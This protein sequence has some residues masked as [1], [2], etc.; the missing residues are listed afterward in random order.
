MCHFTNR[1]NLTISSF[2]STLKTTQNLNKSQISAGANRATSNVQQQSPSQRIL[3]PFTNLN[4]N[5]YTQQINDQPHQRSTTN[6]PSQNIVSPSQQQQEEFPTNYRSPVGGQPQQPQQFSQGQ[7]PNNVATRPPPAPLQQQTSNGIRQRDPNLIPIQPTNI[8]R[9][10][11]PQVQTFN[12]NLQQIRQQVPVQQQ[13]QQ[14]PNP[15]SNHQQILPTIRPEL[16]PQ[17]RPQAPSQQFYENSSHQRPSNFNSMQ[18]PVPLNYPAPQAQQILSPQHTTNQNQP[19]QQSQ[20]QFRPQVPM[21]APVSTGGVVTNHQAN[22]HQVQRELANQSNSVTE[23]NRE[24]TFTTSKDASLEDDDDDVVI[25]RMNTPQTKPMPAVM[26][27]DSRPTSGAP[28]RENNNQQQSQKQQI[29]QQMQPTAPPQ[30]VSRDNKNHVSSSRPP[31]ANVEKLAKS[32]SPDLIKPS[33]NHHQPFQP[34]QQQVNSNLS[35]QRQP[36]TTAPPQQQ[37]QPPQQINKNHNNYDFVRDEINVDDRHE[38]VQRPTHVIKHQ[39]LSDDNNMQRKSPTQNQNHH[40]ANQKHVTQPPKQ[41][42]HQPKPMQRGESITAEVQQQKPQRNQHGDVEQVI[43]KKPEQN[44]QPQKHPENVVHHQQER[45]GN[46]K[47]DLKK[48]T[49]EKLSSKKMLTFTCFSCTNWRRVELK[50]LNIEL[51]T[52]TLKTELDYLN[53]SSRF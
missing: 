45:R 8:I 34:Q 26:K 49:N 15:R 39:Q 33:N 17:S 23:M 38:K 22:S 53:N 44:Q 40:Q 43:K 47:L 7:N 11:Q 3:L 13:Q 41:Q 36:M 4:T 52:N 50:I 5:N 20:Q 9:N 24:K 29:S 1:H 48:S 35:H 30:A 25:G 27:S 12:Q 51:N 21:P 31:S 32:P 16:V 6:R 37:R 10:P 2:S 18:S 28:L 42:Q 14:Q 19:P 46:A